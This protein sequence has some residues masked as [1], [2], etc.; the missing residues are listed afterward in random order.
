MGRSASAAITVTNVA[1]EVD[2]FNDPARPEP[3]QVI[4]FTGSVYDPGLDDTLSY[5]WDFGDNVTATDDL[6]VTHSYAATGTYDVTLT[7]TDDD[8]GVGVISYP[9]SIEPFGADF[10]GYPGVGLPPFTAT[11]YDTSSGMVTNRTW[12]FGDGSPAV[13]TATSTIEH[14]YT[15]PGVYIVSLT[16]NGP[17]GTDAITRPGYIIAVSP[18]TSGTILLEAE[19]YTRQLPGSGDSAW[20]TK[21]ALL[22]YSG[23]GYV[24]AAPDVDILFD[25]ANLITGAELQYDLGLTITGTYAVWLRGYAP[26]A[27]GDSVYVGLDGLQLGNTEYVSD[28][29]PRTWAWGQNLVESSQP[30]TFTVESPGVHT[31][32]LWV[33]EDGFSLDQIILTTDSNFAPGD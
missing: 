3:G 13:T 11:L 9:V 21:T 8:G 27:A 33:R 32:S 1:P 31:L 23:S 20:E 12:N 18:I 19:N 15:T 22:G 26:N 5:A 16:I 4:T 6:T 28:Y 10:T 2:F 29:P 17:S 24:Q 25:D 30:V 7:V 14:V